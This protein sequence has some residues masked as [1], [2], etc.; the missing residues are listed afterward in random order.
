MA[1]IQLRKY[2]KSHYRP[3][4]ERILAAPSLTDAYYVDMEYHTCNSQGSVLD[5]LDRLPECCGLFGDNAMSSLELLDKSLIETQ[6]AIMDEHAR[7]R[8]QL[9]TYPEKE[10]SLLSAR[11]AA[12]S[13]S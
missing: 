9:L 4:L 11:A 8:K 5:M 12:S 2:L 7:N 3:D 1:D 10:N 13:A 6:H